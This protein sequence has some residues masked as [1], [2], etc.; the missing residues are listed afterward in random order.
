MGPPG[1]PSIPGVGVASGD[2]DGSGA[3]DDAVTLDGP[4]LGRG[5]IAASAAGEGAPPPT[6]SINGTVAATTTNADAT[7][8]GP[9]T[10]R[11]TQ[12]ATRRTPRSVA[13][14]QCGEKHRR[15]E[16]GPDD[17]PR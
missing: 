3:L 4:R 2:G 12:A 7:A 13:T 17:A 16:G 15:S 14:G 8:T 1:A 10:R 6:A 9:F 11:Q 5:S